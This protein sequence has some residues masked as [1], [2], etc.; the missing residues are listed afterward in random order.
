MG[1]S[2]EQREGKSPFVNFSWRVDFDKDS[3]HFFFQDDGLGKSEYA[4]FK[5]GSSELDLTAH[6]ENRVGEGSEVSLTF[7]FFAVH[8]FVAFELIKD[9]KVETFAIPAS[10]VKKLIKGEEIRT[11][12]NYHQQIVEA[13]GDSVKRLK[14]P[15]EFSDEEEYKNLV[16]FEDQKKRQ[17]S[18]E[19][20]RFIGFFQSK[21]K[22]SCQQ[23]LCGQYFVGFIEKDGNLVKVLDTDEIAKDIYE[24]S[25]SNEILLPT[26]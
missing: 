14:W 18:L 17:F 16:F 2:P 5:L 12:D 1:Q 23:S 25:R 4:D 15:P 24:S 22:R 13:N 26:G 20:G 19:C 8:E 10:K 11:K 3:F 21:L 7:A 6:I 9:N